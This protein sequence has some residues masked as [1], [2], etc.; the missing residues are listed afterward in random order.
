MVALIKNLSLFNND[1]LVRI[2]Y[3]GQPV[4]YNNQCFAPYQTS[5]SPL[6]NR[7]I[8][9][10]SIGGGFVKYDDWG[11]FEHG[12]GNCD[13]LTFATRKDDSQHHL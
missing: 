1:D 10:I 13:T 4:R 9:R 2:R 11:V 8:F 7:F 6:N 12:A 3:G 5:Y